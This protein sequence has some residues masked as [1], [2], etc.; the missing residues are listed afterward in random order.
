[1]LISQTH[2]QYIHVPV[3][4]TYKTLGK[5][6][7]FSRVTYFFV[8]SLVKI[9]KYERFSLRQNTYNHMKKRIPLQDVFWRYIFGNMYCMEYN[10]LQK[11]L[12]SN[13]FYCIQKS[14]NQAFRIYLL[15]YSNTL[16]IVGA[17][18]R[19]TG[20]RIS[21]AHVQY[22]SHTLLHTNHAFIWIVRRRT[23]RRRYIF[24]QYSPSSHLKKGEK[25]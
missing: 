6:T 12:R 10:K 5:H 14:I 4:G 22:I 17:S 23:R 1:M 21:S 13:E 16:K 11:L 8:S 20:I 25:N 7:R 3:R 18:S 2:A 15:L 24:W 9:W 19:R